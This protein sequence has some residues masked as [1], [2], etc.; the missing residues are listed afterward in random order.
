M[1]S[2]A[3]ASAMPSSGGSERIR[4]G[5]LDAGVA[6]GHAFLD[7]CHRQPAGAT[8]DRGPGHGHTPVPVA[9]GLDDGAEGRRRHRPPQ[10]GGVVTDGTEVDVGP[11]RPPALLRPPLDIPVL[12]HPP[13]RSVRRP[14][15]PGELRQHV[16]H[17]VGKV[18]GHQ[19]LGRVRR[20]AARPWTWAAS[21][22]AS[23][24]DTPGPPWPR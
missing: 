1:R 23:R 3:T 4:I 16:G 17:E 6:K 9:V 10:H 19:A 7:E 24:G 2:R 11:G 15:A 21:A 14:S 20:P 8:L 13:L 22:A 5:H 12:S 18:A